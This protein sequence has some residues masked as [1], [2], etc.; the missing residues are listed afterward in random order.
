[1]F[2]G[3]SLKDE[4]GASVPRAPGNRL[5]RCPPA[6]PQRQ[7]AINRHPLRDI[8]LHNTAQKYI[9]LNP[10]GNLPRSKML[11]RKSNLPS[12]EPDARL[13]KR[14][15]VEENQPYTENKT[16][17]TTAKVSGLAFRISNIPCTMS[18]Q[19]F[20]QIFNALQLN[21][22]GL[23]DLGGQ[24]VLGWSFTPSAASIDA[25]RYMTATVTFRYLPIDFEFRGTSTSLEI[26]PSVTSVIIDKHFY[27]MT[28]LNTPRDPT[29]EYASPLSRSPS[30]CQLISLVLSL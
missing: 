18:E 16:A 23:F 14:I 27:G 4:W 28:P 10:F 12:P 8:Y 5:L 26:F 13:H 9:I 25:G 21:M 7:Q 6:H 11:K 17:V 3:I 22:S 29:V 1:M 24:N 19:Q 20:L 2:L 30:T 15:T